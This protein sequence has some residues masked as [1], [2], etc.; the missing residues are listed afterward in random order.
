MYY[1]SWGLLFTEMLYFSWSQ[2]SNVAFGQ[3]QPLLI[4]YFPFTAAGWGRS[5]NTPA[6]PKTD[7]SL[8]QQQKYDKNFWVTCLLFFHSF[9][10]CGK[11]WNNFLKSIKN[12]ID[13]CTVYFCLTLLIKRMCFLISMFFCFALVPRT[14]DFHWYWYRIQKC[15]Y[16]DNTRNYEKVPPVWKPLITPPVETPTE[17]YTVSKAFRDT[18]SKLKIVPRKGLEVMGGTYSVQ[19]YSDFYVVGKGLIYHCQQSGHKAKK[20]VGVY[21]EDRLKVNFMAENGITGK[22]LSVGRQC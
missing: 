17:T 20:L 13:F 8:Q 18:G 14:V 16:R 15:W 2:W 9:I 11:T 10:T 4:L 12:G 1:I 21:E 6:N 19:K 3:T 22:S 7:N 5:W